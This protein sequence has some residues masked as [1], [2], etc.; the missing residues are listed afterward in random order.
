LN[1]RHSDR[2]EESAF[3]NLPK[4]ALVPWADL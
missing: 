2:S 4:P 1:W 3:I